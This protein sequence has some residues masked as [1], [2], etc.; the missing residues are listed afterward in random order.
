MRYILRSKMTLATA[1]QRSARAHR[2]LLRPTPSPRPD[3]HRPGRA[4]SDQQGHDRRVSSERTSISRMLLDSDPNHR[5]L[6]QHQERHRWAPGD[7]DPQPLHGVLPRSTSSS[8]TARAHCSGC[9]SGKDRRLPPPIPLVLHPARRKRCSNHSE[10][11]VRIGA[12]LDHSGWLV[13]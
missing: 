9:S 12:P 3:A 6:E 4:K 13:F 10:P 7:L 1:F 5:P 2:L 8:K 11:Q